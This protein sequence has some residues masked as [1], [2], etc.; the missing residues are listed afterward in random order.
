MDDRL[1]KHKPDYKPKAY[2][3]YTITQLGGIVEFFAQRASHRTNEE[4]KRK[5]LY[6]AKNYLW[7]MEQKLRKKCSD[8]GIDFDSL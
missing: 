4:K 1:E 6:D 2:E 8:L 7:M 5:D 3:A